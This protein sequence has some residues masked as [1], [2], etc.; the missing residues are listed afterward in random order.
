[1]GIG[2][3]CSYHMCTHKSWFISYEK[4]F[5][6]NVLMGNNASCKSF[7]IGSI[8]IRMHDGIVRTLNDFLHVPKLKKNLVF[9]GVVDLK[10]FSS[11]VE[12]GA[13]QIRGKMNFMVMQRTKARKVVHPSRVHYD[14]LYLCCFIIWKPCIH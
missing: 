5:D 2:L 3:S 7:G 13:L 12:N 10:G 8:Q 6:G 1:M 14:R 4:K 11:W 9:V